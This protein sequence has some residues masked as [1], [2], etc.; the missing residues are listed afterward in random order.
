[1][2]TEW[3]LFLL[4]GLTAGTLGSLIGLGG[5][6]ITVPALL[7]LASL[8]PEL[9][10]MTP[11][12]AVGTSLVLVIITALSSTLSFTR[13]KRVD[14]RS[15]WVFFLASGPG[16]ILGAYLTHFFNVNMFYVSFGCIMILIA[17]ILTFRDRLKSRSVQW[18]VKREFTDLE[19][20]VH[21]YG[22]HRPTAWIV[23][24]IV[25]IISGLFGIGGGALLVPMMV[26]LF[27]FPPHVATSTS[28][29]IIFLSAVLG[30]IT[31]FTQGNIDWQAVLLIAPGAWVGGKLGAWISRKMSGRALLVA[32]RLAI[33]M[34]A[35]RMMIQGFS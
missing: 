5:G 10:Y 31:H 3:I 22:Y 25:G 15:G 11:Q 14:F 17:G 20:N 1:M 12:L 13:Q 19:G 34:V 26:L 29:F 21:R 8:F 35:F 9:N 23:S 4:I 27:R 24:F 16:A 30:S 18:S 6:I 32:L 33:V 7:L 28:M 2:L